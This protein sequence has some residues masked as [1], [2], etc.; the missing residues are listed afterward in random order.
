[1]AL[2]AALLN[3]SLGRTVA[4]FIGYVELGPISHFDRIVAS[5]T[6]LWPVSEKI[7]IKE[8]R[9]KYNFRVT[10]LSKLG[11]GQIY[12]N[13]EAMVTHFHVQIRTRY[14]GFER[15]CCWWEAFL[16]WTANKVGSGVNYPLFVGIGV[17]VF[18]VVTFRIVG[19][20]M[21]ITSC[22]FSLWRRF[23]S[24]A[25]MPFTIATRG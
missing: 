23:F 18:K 25:E 7:S 5:T 12:N 6:F 14:G 2:S 1:V 19:Q 8:N 21:K 20:K 3:F 15:R 22:V 11:L 16:A 17:R 4:F 9:S 10:F 13:L 24:S